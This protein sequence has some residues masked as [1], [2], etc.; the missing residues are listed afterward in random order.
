MN[1][2]IDYFKLYINIYYIFLS[3]FIY[4]TKKIDTKMTNIYCA[5]ISTVTV[6]PK[7]K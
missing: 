4:I 5:M 1:N 3:K 7:K 2:L 6:R